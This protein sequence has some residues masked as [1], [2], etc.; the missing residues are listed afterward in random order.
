MRWCWEGWWWWRFKRT[1]GTGI[2]KSC[3][4]TLSLTPLERHITREN[5]GRHKQTARPPR[6]NALETLVGVYQRTTSGTDPINQ[7]QCGLRVSC[8][9]HTF[10][11]DEQT[12]IPS[13]VRPGWVNIER[14][15]EMRG[16][17]CCG[18][19]PSFIHWGGSSEICSHSCSEYWRDLN[20]VLGMLKLFVQ[21][22]KLKWVPFICD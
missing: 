3:L 16:G 15:E 7:I 12:T 6:V 2:V 1:L 22:R 14:M 4:F 17:W 5:K 19:P 9:I 20:H 21:T 11:A 13:S 18:Y 10:A 8:L